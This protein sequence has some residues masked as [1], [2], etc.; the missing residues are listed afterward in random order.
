[1]DLEV[2]IGAL[3]VFWV[4]CYRFNAPPPPKPSQPEGTSPVL[5]VIKGLFQWKEEPDSSLFPPPRANTT[6]FKFWLYR[7]AYT[8]TGLAVYFTMYKVP[9]V[10]KAVQQIINM[11]A[12]S[13]TPILKDAG[14]VVIAFIVAAIF[15]ELPPLKGAERA[16]RRL[17]YERALI[18][19]QQL[20]ERTRLKEAEYQ[21]HPAVLEA[22]RK[23]LEVEGFEGSDIV[24]DATPTV[25]SLWT[26]ASLLIAHLA[27]WQGKDKYKTAFAVLRERDSDK[28]SVHYVT[29]AYEALKGDAKVCFKARREHPGAPETEA[30][31]AA[32]RREC[33]ALLGH[34]YD[35]LSRLSLKS[36][37]TERERIKCMAEL[38]FLLE[39]REGGPV[40]DMNDL[41]ALALVLSA[42]LIVPLSLRLDLNRA[43]LIGVITYTAVLIPILI[44][45]RFPEFARKAGG[46][47]PAIAFPVVSGII[48]GAVGM[49]F[50][51]VSNSIAA[52]D[53][54]SGVLLDFTKGWATYTGRSYPWSTLHAI[55]AALVAWR[56]RT[57]T[58]PDPTRLKG[59][60]RYRAWGNLW[61]AGIFVGCVVAWMV[62]FVRPQV[63]KLLNRPEVAQDWRFLIIPVMAALAMGFFVP[64]WYRA[65]LLRMTKAKEEIRPAPGAAPA[66]P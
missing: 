62:V 11:A 23:K 2:A 17:L 32:F 3:I 51:V 48:A 13:D 10:A 20:S 5:G 25:R 38:G 65:N 57:G 16:V 37:L 66:T 9:G 28:L 6:L 30:R 53:L 63:A 40:P 7:I 39:P 15:P 14:P 26:K 8:C 24:Y 18:P 43:L 22:V 61:D 34:L 59:I 35:L 1:M 27:R 52:G 50:S 4:A 33:K 47:T 49:V 56:I 44:A 46:G 42:V 29:E 60:A 21:V 64:T 54:G 31:E 36:H 55:M 19:A 45:N 12:G 58:Y 41:V